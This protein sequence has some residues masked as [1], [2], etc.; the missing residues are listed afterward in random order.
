MIHECNFSFWMNFSIHEETFFNVC[1]IINTLQATFWG[2]LYYLLHIWKFHFKFNVNSCDDTLCK[3]SN[4]IQIFNFSIC[5][6]DQHNMSLYQ[7]CIP[8]FI[9]ACTKPLLYLLFAF[10]HSLQ[11]YFKLFILFPWWFV[12]CPLET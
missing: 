10:A 4:T 9:N 7:M 12:E 2:I 3:L 1:S 11:Y 6:L 8:I 5:L